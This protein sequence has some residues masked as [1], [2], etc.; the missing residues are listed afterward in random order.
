MSEIWDW[1]RGGCSEGRACSVEVLHWGVQSLCRQLHSPSV[2]AEQL[3][4]TRCSAG[5]L[6]IT[7]PL[8]TCEPSHCTARQWQPGAPPRTTLCTL[9]L[10]PSPVHLNLAVW[11]QPVWC[12]VDDGQS[13]RQQNGGLRLISMNNKNKQTRRWGRR[14]TEAI[15]LSR[16]ISIVY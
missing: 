14:V 11:K 16:F 1:G 10:S 2:A 6:L 4:G 8:L 13:L 5:L 9:R 3:A 7:G 12:S 15:P